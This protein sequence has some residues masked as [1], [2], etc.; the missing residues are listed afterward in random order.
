MELLAVA[1]GAV[2]FHEVEYSKRFHKHKS[3]LWNDVGQK[4][5]QEMHK[6]VFFRIQL[7][8]YIYVTSINASSN[9]IKRN[10]EPSFA[11]NVY[12]PSVVLTLAG[13]QHRQFITHE[14]KLN[15]LIK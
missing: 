13:V 6:L 4:Y 14:S 9:R 8:V 15:K 1:Y 11:V 2:I 10:G 3:S 5:A 7:K 12:Q